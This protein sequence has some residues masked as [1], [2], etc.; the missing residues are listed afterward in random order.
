PRPWAGNAGGS[1]F[2]PA[3][4]GKKRT[5]DSASTTT[6]KRAWVATLSFV[7]TQPSRQPPPGGGRSC[8]RWDSVLAAQDSSLPPDTLRGDRIRHGRFPRH[9]F[10]RRGQ[11]WLEAPAPLAGAEPGF[12]TRGGRALEGRPP[13]RSP[14]RS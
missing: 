14:G 9:V 8:S 13:P 11:T 4:A 6:S 10:F 2:G 7:L 1:G 5:A 12:V 3:V